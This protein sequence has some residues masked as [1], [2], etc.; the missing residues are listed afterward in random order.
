MISTKFNGREIALYL[1]GAAMFELDEIKMLWNDG[2]VEPVLGVQEL[3]GEMDSE[4][5]QVLAQTVEILE[6]AALGA[7][8][9]LGREEFQ[10]VT[11][12]EILTLA[13]PLDIV[14]LQ[15]AAMRAIVEGYRTDAEHDE[16]VDVYMLENL[17]KK[18]EGSPEPPT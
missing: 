9:V 16:P 17:K 8:K 14:N 13:K 7:N 1:S 6:R 2:H 5:I 10:V 12:N 4:R 3:L 15:T 11:A 18:I